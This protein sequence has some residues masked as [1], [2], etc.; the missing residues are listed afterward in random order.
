MTDLQAGPGDHARVHSPVKLGYKNSKY[1]TEIVF[2][3]NHTGGYWTDRG[4][5]WHGG[6]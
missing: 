6:T 2:R 3:R 5:E 1:L 4:Y